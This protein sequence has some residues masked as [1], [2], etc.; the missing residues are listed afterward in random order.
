MDAAEIIQ[1]VRQIEIKSR[2]LSDHVFAGEYHT[3]FKGRGMNFSEVREYSYGD[4]VRHIDWNVSAR[5]QHP[6]VKLFQEERELTVHILL[7]ISAST[8]LSAAGQRRD[9]MT[10]L[11]AVL[12]FSVIRNQDSAGLMLFDNEVRAYIPP[13][14]NK[15]HLMHMTGV[16]ASAEPSNNGTNITTALEYFLKI[17]KRKSI[18][19]LIS[20]FLESGYKE[21]VQRVSSRHDLIGLLIKDPM[22][23]QL[24]DIGL[25]PVMDAESGEQ[26]WMDTS[27]KYYQDVYSKRY[28]KAMQYF[29]D[30][31]GSAGADTLILND[32]DVY[33]KDLKYFLHQRTKK[34]GR[35]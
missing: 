2:L 34:G 22:D 19:F 15:S 20:D 28:R 10:E 1:K 17:Q 8:L 9:F 24:P 25:I 11:A 16:L 29:K 26:F 7:D 21:L 18:I 12:A 23:G 27:D 5:M 3:A 35:L 32:H 31:F 30:A 4:D 33:L 13:A 14:K 6:F